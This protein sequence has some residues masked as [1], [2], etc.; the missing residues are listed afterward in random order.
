MDSSG[1]IID[2]KY[3]SINTL[4]HELS[5]PWSSSEVRQH[6]TAET[7]DH[8]SNE[9]NK[10]QRNTKWR[11]LLAILNLEQEDQL[12]L[13]GSIN[14]LLD[15][16][17]Q[18]EDQWVKTTAALVRRWLH[19]SEANTQYLDGLMED[20]MKEI[21]SIATQKSD[22]IEETPYFEP[23][24]LAFLKK[25]LLPPELQED[26]VFNT[27]PHFQVD[28]EALERLTSDDKEGFRKR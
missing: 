9:Y 17:D 4:V 10:I 5:G 21:A 6:L 2:P 12:Q 19:G 25:D 11:V 23:M 22:Q 15:V 13:K 16:A 27:N 3:E 24:E 1:S 18:D 7:L 28:F 20:T 26:E 14:N 8:L